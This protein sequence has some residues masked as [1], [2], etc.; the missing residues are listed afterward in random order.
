MYSFLLYS[1]EN[2]LFLISFTGSVIHS[3]IPSIKPPIIIRGLIDWLIMVR[4]SI[5]KLKTFSW[6][7]VHRCF[8]Y[9]IQFSYKPAIPHTFYIWSF[10]C[11]LFEYSVIHPFFINGWQEYVCKS[12][13]STLSKGSIHKCIALCHEILRT[14][15]TEQ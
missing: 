2:K 11:I 6:L 12:I 15:D 4:L 13:H 8:L 3:F 5:R 10:Y 1:S 9:S 14:Y 7:F